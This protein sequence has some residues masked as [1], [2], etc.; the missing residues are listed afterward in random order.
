MS[1]WNT[2]FDGDFLGRFAFLDALL[3]TACEGTLLGMLVAAV[4]RRLKQNYRLHALLWTAVFLVPLAHLFAG[5]IVVIPV[6]QFGAAL[7]V[8]ALQEPPALMVPRVRLD[9]G[10]PL[11]RPTA[12]AQQDQ[13]LP[14]AVFETPDLESVGTTHNLAAWAL[15]LWAVGACFL[16]ARY[17][18]Q[19]LA[20]ARLIRQS[21]EPSKALSDLF[22]AEST[23]LPAW[24]PLRIRALDRNASPGV[25]GVLFP[26]IIMPRWLEDEAHR[27]LATFAL[28]HEI[29]HLR[30]GDTLADLLRHAACIV[31]WFH[32]GVWW[33]SRQ[34]EQSAESACDLASVDQALD[35]R[36]YADYLLQCCEYV[37]ANGSCTYAVTMNATR[38]NVVRRVHALLASRLKPARLDRRLKILL[39]TALVLLMLVGFGMQSSS[40]LAAP[41]ARAAWRDVV[42]QLS[43][44]FPGFSE[45]SSYAPAPETVALGERVLSFPDGG[46]AGSLEVDGAAIAPRGQ[47]R[48]GAGDVVMLRL[49]ASQTPDLSFLDALPVDAIQELNLRCPVPDEQLQHVGRLVGLQHLDLFKSGISDAGLAHLQPL[50]NLL[51]LDLNST[52]ISDLGLTYLADMQ[53]L[54]HLDI[55]RTRVTDEGMATLAQIP[56]L[57][58]I[59]LWKTAVTDAG[60]ERLAALPGITYIGLEDNAITDAALAHFSRWPHLQEADLEHTFVTDAGVEVFSQL[61]EMRWLDLTDTRVTPASSPVLASLANLE[62]LNLPITWSAQDCAPLAKLP[63]YSSLPNLRLIHPVTLRVTDARSGA[64]VDGA[65]L[66]FIPGQAAAAHYD[67]NTNAHIWT[68]PEGTVTVF[69]D[70]VHAS[71]QLTVLAEGYV[72]QGLEI[73]LSQ[74]APDYPLQIEIGLEP[75]IEIG[76]IVTDPD[77]V[78]LEGATVTVP[79][80]AGFNVDSDAPLY[81]RALSA[82]DGSWSCPVAPDDL[83]GFWVEVAHPDFQPQ[84]YSGPSVESALRAGNAEMYVWYPGHTEIFVGDSQGQLIRGAYVVL[85]QPWRR[86]GLNATE[87][88]G[89]AQGSFSAD[90][91][92]IGKHQLRVSAPGY[93]SKEVEIEVTSLNGMP[94]TVQ[95]DEAGAPQG[96]TH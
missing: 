5:P 83:S 58:Y 52:F 36:R 72:S 12:P 91:L 73:D 19:R 54:Q 47:V 74:A 11:P 95:L 32:P 20:I 16:L 22:H 56:S 46:I 42:S 38:S 81:Y 84:R 66:I 93:V 57:T 14:R 69:T 86:D 9:M 15:G 35:A 21:P 7:P 10:L 4:T 27:D 24:F 62:S 82:E 88:A 44:I 30:H 6:A 28:R 31:Y 13:P 87:C 90:C 33:A 23:C 37:Q 79:V 64:A 48:A 70:P 60:V 96:E 51:M 53:R 89:I 55:N 61:P 92:T 1:F 75:G 63:A 2:L 78:P 3:V 25:V 17:L 50:T 45:D 65:G 77:G 18:V 85:M 29:M 26:V 59:D 34:W 71:A 80:I 76:G 39:G 8:Q 94:I 49:D 68:G 43:G 41:N 67:G 40:I